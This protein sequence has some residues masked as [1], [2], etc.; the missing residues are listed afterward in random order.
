VLEYDRRGVES[1]G[2]IDEIDEI[3]DWDVTVP[4]V[5]PATGS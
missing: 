4:P 3:D 2:E 5:A 1:W